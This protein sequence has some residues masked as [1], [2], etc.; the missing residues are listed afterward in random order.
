MAGRRR[1]VKTLGRAWALNRNPGPFL[2]TSVQWRSQ[3]GSSSRGKAAGL[4]DSWALAERLRAGP[5]FDVSLH[6]VGDGVDSVCGARG[7]GRSKT[8]RAEDLVK[9]KDKKKVSNSN[10]RRAKLVG[11]VCMCAD[12]LPMYYLYLVVYCIPN[13]GDGKRGWG[14]V[15]TSP[16]HEEFVVVEWRRNE[17]GRSRPSLSCATTLNY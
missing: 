16:R 15:Q 14:C 1:P 2:G 17:V 12:V 13:G 6:G 11:I 7:E 4:T 9:D 8:Q 10:R 5:T 3:S